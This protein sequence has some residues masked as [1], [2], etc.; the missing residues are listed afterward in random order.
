[1]K[2]LSST[3]QLYAC[4]KIYI[5]ALIMNGNFNFSRQPFIFGLIKIN[6]IEK[7]M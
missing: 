4:G 2:I 6:L 5:R 1:M 7:N 3:Y